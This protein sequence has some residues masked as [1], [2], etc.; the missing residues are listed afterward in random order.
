MDKASKL[1][2]TLTVCP[3]RDYEWPYVFWPSECSSHISKLME[4]C[5]GKL[6][7]NCCLIYLNDIIVFSKT[8]KGYLTQLRAVFQK[9]KEVGLKLKLRKHGF[10][11]KSLAF[12]EHKISWKGF[13]TNDCKMK[14]IWEWPAPKTVSFKALGKG[15]ECWY[16]V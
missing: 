8:V 14:A 15:T 16:Y 1:L 5:L 7:L 9:L 3:H 10:L 13:K 2:M 4:I 11:K 12:L 6:E